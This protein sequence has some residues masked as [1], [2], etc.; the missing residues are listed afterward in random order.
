MS[1]KKR[2]KVPKLRFSEFEDE[3]DFLKLR[4]VASIQTGLAKG[5]SKELRDPVKMPY[6]RVANVQEGY[7]DLSVV[8]EI[9]VEKEKVERYL[10]KYDDVL[11]TE[12]GDFDKLGRGT[13]WK[14]QIEKCLHQNHIFVVRPN[15]RKLIP[16]YLESVIKGFHGKKYFQLASKQTTNLATI[17][18]TQLKDFPIP[19]PSVIEQEKI[20]SFLGAIASHLSQLHRKHDLLQTYKRGVMQKIFSQQIRFKQDDGSGFPDWKHKTLG[21]IAT[22]QTK[23]N[24]DASIVRVLTNS[25]TQGVVDQQDYFD[26]DIANAN[27]LFGYYVIDK[28]DFVY[29]PRVSATAPVG[30]INKNNVAQGVMSPLYTVF[31]FKNPDNQFYE[32]Y[33]KT[34]FWHK[35]MCSVANYGARHDRMNIVVS[36]FLNLPLPSPCQE[37]QEK[38]TQLVN[39]IDDKISAV[40]KQIEEVEKFKQGLL[41]K[42]FV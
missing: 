12:G 40:N 6:I 11:L 13:L 32:Q 24:E 16:E 5:G 31:R 42:M 39:A 3:W 36:D 29:N 38:I 10:L 7:L 18:S 9:I 25:A 27:N 15:A 33:F 22:R 4:D 8:K 14:N 26:K 21:K 19:L 30:P 37:E 34:S 20:V 41:Q 23:K 28:G 35:Y 1:R 17:N 2:K